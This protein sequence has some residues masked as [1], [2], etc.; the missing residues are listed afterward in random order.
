MTQ[1]GEPPRRSSLTTLLQEV[2][3][4]HVHPENVYEVA[5]LVE[6]MGW[7]D[8]RINER[9]GYQ[10]VFELSEQLWLML[11]KT[12]EFQGHDYIQ[13]EPWHSQL[14]E[15]VREFLRGAIFALPM[16]L[17]IASMLFFRFSLWSYQNLSTE[18]ATAIAIG[19]ILSFLSVG[20][21]MQAISR[22]G[23]FYIYQGYFR[24][25]SRIT[26][27][28]IFIG[29]GLSVLV[30]LALI[31]TNILFPLLP[32]IM[33]FIAIA[34]YLVLNS[35]W[36]AVAALY[37]LQREI[38]FTCLLLVG[39]L[40]VFIEF[41]ILH[42]NILL[43]QLISMATISVAGIFA[44]MYLFGR[45]ETESERGINPPLPRMS[46]TVY[47]VAP[48]FSY[49]CLYFL[50]LFADR[51]IAWSTNSGFMPLDFWF[52]GDYE[53]GLDF[54]LIMLVIPMGVSEVVIGEMMRGVF[55]SQ[56]KYALNDESALGTEYL[57]RFR[58]GRAIMVIASCASA[59]SVYF[60][61]ENL[62]HS[63]FIISRHVVI[64]TATTNYVFIVG[65]V[66]YTILGI[67]L[68]NTVTMFSFSRPDGV[69][70]PLILSIIVDVLLGFILSRWIG[71][72]QAVIG[73]LAGSLLFMW[74][75]SRNVNKVLKDVDYHLYLLS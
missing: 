1:V 28:F 68:L 16:V 50:L 32:D 36:L 29:I 26:F 22:R 11:D 9:F 13:S 56:R 5:A 42:W 25:A 64:I 31:V 46:V 7:T 4:R 44:V 67:A 38:I 75:T 20:G 43:S 3:E 8:Q 39:M 6:S 19:T 48:Y 47:S 45:S 52:R 73:I 21:F 51:I 72:A 40:F 15:M 10:D 41:K 59:I 30:S 24:M 62:M 14:R 70:R 34:F 61:I 63:N 27:R 66:S 71:Y 69:L 35:I 49:G 60:I 55:L 12:V 65:L 57:R 37:M 23:F 54:A 17:S 2:T 58:R 33:L 74:L 53:V 18:Y